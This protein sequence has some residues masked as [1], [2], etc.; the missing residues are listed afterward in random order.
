MK[1][2]K[3]LVFGVALLVALSACGRTKYEY[4][5]GER[6]ETGAQG[7]AGPQGNPGTPGDDGVDGQDA[8]LEVIDPC[9]D[10]PSVVD[11]ILLRLADGSVLCSFSANANG[12]NTRLAILPPGSYVTTDGSN[13]HFTVTAQGTIQ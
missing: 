13:C 6:G 11:E 1:C 8:V 2:K 9:G 7:P 10:A 3:G 12:Q 4:F 5:V